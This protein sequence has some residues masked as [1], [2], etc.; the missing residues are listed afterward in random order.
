MLC[1]FSGGS[2]TLEWPS[3]AKTSLTL[4]AAT[5]LSVASFAAAPSSRGLRLSLGLSE[6]TGA[7]SAGGEDISSFSVAGSEL[8]K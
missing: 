7:S 3:P 6:R 8:E 5:A 1:I 4:L 2:E